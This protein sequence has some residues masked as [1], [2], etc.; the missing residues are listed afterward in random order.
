MVPATTPTN[1]HDQT[2]A[3]S[4]DLFLDDLSQRY[5]VVD[6]SKLIEPAAKHFD[7]LMQERYL[8]CED[9]GAH[10]DKVWTGVMGYTL[11][12]MSHVG[13]VPGKPGQ[14]LLAGFNGHGMP[15]I[16]LCAKG[17]A[18]M[19]EE[20]ES[21]EEVGLPRMFKTTMERLNSTKNSL[22]NGDMKYEPKATFD[23]QEVQRKDSL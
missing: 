14:Y 23:E 5:G 22:L 11:D 3:P 21:F 16:F 20:G 17:I 1:A 7:A 18:E 15:R 2:P 12:L 13:E 6:D 8:G 10:V 9:S 19:L 4:L